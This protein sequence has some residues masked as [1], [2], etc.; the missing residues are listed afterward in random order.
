[1]RLLIDMNLA[2]RW[3]NYLIDA[4]HKAVHRSDDASG[5]VGRT[6]GRT[7]RS[8]W[9]APVPPPESGARGLRAGEGARPTEQC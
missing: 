8:A 1:M 2:P 6:P 7:P 3:V 4:G 5:L 9:D